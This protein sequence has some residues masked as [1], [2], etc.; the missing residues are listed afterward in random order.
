[1]TLAE[2]FVDYEVCKAEVFSS[3]VLDDYGAEAH[4]S[5]VFEIVGEKSREMLASPV[6]NSC[7]IRPGTELADALSHYRFPG[8]MMVM[9]VERRPG[10]WCVEF[11]SK[12]ISGSAGFRLDK[13]EMTK[14]LSAIE[15]V[16]MGDVV[17]EKIM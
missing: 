3:V 16:A 12:L 14:I 7:R 10:D 11:H 2:R 1:M 8:G 15:K 5:Y 4:D 6:L 17:E 9:F 13:H